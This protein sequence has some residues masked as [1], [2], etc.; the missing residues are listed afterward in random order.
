MINLSGLKNMRDAEHA[1]RYKSKDQMEED[2]G[3]SLAQ[4]STSLK[5]LIKVI[6]LDVSTTVRRAVLKAF[7]TMVLISPVDRGPYMCSHDIAVGREPG[8]DEGV[9][10][11]PPEGTV[12]PRPPIR[13]DLNWN[14]GDGDIWLF[15]NL[16][17][18]EYLERGHSKQAPLGIYTVALA[19][20]AA[21]LE[22][23][24]T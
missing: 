1:L 19:Q 20:I 14:V 15:N 18:A 4:F 11:R 2:L 8:D 12:L 7:N 9:V 16:K 10:P 17:Y 13:M 24:I 6:E 21:E 23:E 22:G 5:N 3:E